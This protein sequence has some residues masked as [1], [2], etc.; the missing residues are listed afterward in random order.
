MTPTAKDYEKAKSILRELLREY[1][2]E[3][4]GLRGLSSELIAQALADE[5][6]RCAVISDSYWDDEECCACDSKCSNL[7][8]KKI[9]SLE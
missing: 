7:I 9:M 2:R 5:R 3:Y 6:E 1:V 4:E 8:A